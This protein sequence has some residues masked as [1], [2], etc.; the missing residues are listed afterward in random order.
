MII[1]QTTKNHGHPLSATSDARRKRVTRQKEGRKLTRPS[2]KCIDRPIRLTPDLRSRSFEM[3]IEITFILWESLSITYVSPMQNHLEN[4]IKWGKGNESVEIRS[5][6][7][8]V[9]RRD[10]SIRVCRIARRLTGW[11]RSLPFGAGHHD[12]MQH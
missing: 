10:Y 5:V 4:K 1:D 11:T 8:S 12:E 7:F 6:R 9:R 2:N 3:R